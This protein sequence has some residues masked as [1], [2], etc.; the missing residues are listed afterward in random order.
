MKS[1]RNIF[2]RLQTRMS[3]CQHLQLL[4]NWIYEFDSKTWFRCTWMC[5]DQWSSSLMICSTHF[6]RHNAHEIWIKF[7]TFRWHYFQS[8]ITIS[9][10]MRGHVSEITDKRKKRE[11]QML[12]TTKTNVSSRELQKLPISFDR[13]HIHIMHNTRLYRSVRREHIFTTNQFLRSVHFHFIHSP[14]GSIL[15]TWRV[16]IGPLCV[17]YYLLQTSMYHRVCVCMCVWLSL[18]LDSY[19]LC[20]LVHQLVVRGFCFLLF[21]YAATVVT[22]K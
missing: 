4:F 13:I 8:F 7:L 18:Q 3:L 21:Y 10:T 22:Y 1:G 11:E 20:S 17:E 15:F 14:G 19:S 2:N 6:Q 16:S 5:D 12:Y 9:P